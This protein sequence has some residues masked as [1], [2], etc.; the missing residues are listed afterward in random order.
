MTTN[1]ETIIA[2]LDEVR[3][4]LVRAKLIELKQLTARQKRFLG[5]E[6][7]AGKKEALNLATAGNSLS[8]VEKVLIKQGFVA[9]VFE[10]DDLNH[11]YQK[12]FGKLKLGA[13]VGLTRKGVYI[14]TCLL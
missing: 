8:A 13:T 12:K 1:D 7:V 11:Q 6:V 10:K 2:A 3:E 9:K 14:Y 5:F 4:A